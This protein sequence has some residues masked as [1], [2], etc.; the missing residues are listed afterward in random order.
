MLFLIEQNIIIC[1]KCCCDLIKNVFISTFLKEE[2][3]IALIISGH[4]HLK[5][6][7][8]PPTKAASPHGCHIIARTTRCLPA[9]HTDFPDLVIQ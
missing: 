7:A 5:R 9:S 3:K 8:P 2:S 4:A 1:I 6:V